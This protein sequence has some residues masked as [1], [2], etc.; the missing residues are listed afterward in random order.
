MFDMWIGGTGVVVVILNIDQAI[1]FQRTTT[2]TLAPS[3]ANQHPVDN[4]G[5]DFP[6]VPFVTLPMLTCRLLWRIL[7]AGK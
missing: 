3:S 4:K 1:I 6:Q 5:I 2:Y 7:L